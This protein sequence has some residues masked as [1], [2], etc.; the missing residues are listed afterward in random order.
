M[1]K[2]KKSCKTQVAAR[3]RQT[4]VAVVKMEY[5]SLLRCIAMYVRGLPIPVL[6]IY[7]LCYVRSLVM[8]VI[9]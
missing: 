9:Y 3:H 6:K 2:R 8:T 4:N 7:V 1:P 5:A